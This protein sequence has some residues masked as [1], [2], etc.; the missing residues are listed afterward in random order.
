MTLADAACQWNL[1][2]RD[3]LMSRRTSLYIGIALALVILGRLLSTWTPAAT[4]PGVSLSPSSSSH[5]NDSAAGSSP[6]APPPATLRRP[7]P[8]VA[9]LGVLTDRPRAD[10]DAL[11]RRDRMAALVAPAYCGDEASCAAV[12]TVLDDPDA[13]TLQVIDASDWNLGRVDVDAGAASLS[14]ADRA[15]LSKRARVVVVRVATAT[16]PRQLAVRTAF[17]AAAAISMACDG[18]VHDPLLARVETSRAFAAHAVTEPLE[19]SA[20][21]RDR[22]ELLYE[23]KEEGVVRVLTAGLSRWGAPD[24]EAARVPMAARER[25]AEIV[26]AVARALADGAERGPVTL[27]RDDIGRA[28][29][30]AY[31]AD[32]GLPPLA[33][34]TIELASVRPEAGDPNDFIARIE[35]PES[36]GPM[37][38]LDLAERF[39]G[40]LLLSP[41]EPDPTHEHRAEAQRKL[42]RSLVRWGSSRAHGDKLLVQLPFAI[43]GDAGVESMWVEVTRY[44]ARTVT[45]TLLNEPLG[46]TDVTRGETITRPREQVEDVRTAAP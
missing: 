2:R 20:F 1:V 39:F 34:V 8:S 6:V 32:A 22:V 10:L 43:P 21:R 11:V 29:G 27:S 44:D 37:G 25:L 42:A 30:W 40:P 35:P 23:P 18:L 36:D 5:S 15:S 16:S 33:P 9:V 4:P 31:P 45:G 26:L 24:V 38:Y 28:R 14:P 19:A 13:T 7:S 17:A 46:A 41:P 12:R 3:S